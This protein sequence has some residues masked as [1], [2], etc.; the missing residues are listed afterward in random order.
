M[1]VI[2]FDANLEIENSWILGSSNREICSALEKQTDGTI[3]M[4][5]YD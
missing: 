5:V 1:I 3:A 2:K 4:S